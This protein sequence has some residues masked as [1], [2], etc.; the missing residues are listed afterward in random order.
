MKLA[1][2]MIVRLGRIIA[3][4]LLGVITVAALA[5]L[6]VGVAMKFDLST[7]L[8]VVGGAVLLDL[9]LDDVLSSRRPA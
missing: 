9:T 5:A 7:A 3:P 2:G 1:R 4:R 6:G 8:I